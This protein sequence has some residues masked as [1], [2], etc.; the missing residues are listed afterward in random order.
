MTGMTRSQTTATLTFAQK[1]AAAYEKYGKPKDA[2]AARRH[3]AALEA[4][5]AEIDRNTTQE[6]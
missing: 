2:D 6:E 3:A 1:V 4:Q 5:L